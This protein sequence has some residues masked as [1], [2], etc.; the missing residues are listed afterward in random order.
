MKKLPVISIIIVN[1]NGKRWLKPC[2]E[3]VFR[4]TYRHFEVI[5]VDNGSGDDSVEYLAENFPKVKV[6]PLDQNLGFA[7]GNNAGIAKAKGDIVFL[8]NNDTVIDKDMLEKIVPIFD[9]PKIG[10]VQPKIV[11]QR[12]PGKLDL[13]G[14]FWT[15]TTFLSYFGLRADSTLQK[16][17]EPLKVFSNKGAAMFVRK[18]MLDKIGSFDED[19]WCYYE[20]TDLCHRAWL[21][22]FECWY[23]PV[24]TCHHANG[25]TS[26]RLENSFIQFHNFK[27]KFL[28]FLKNFEARSLVMIIPTYLFCLLGLIVFFGLKGEG[29]KSMA[30]IKSLI[31]NVQKFPKT[32]Q[33]RKDVQKLRRLKD[34]EYLP[35][36][37]KSLSLKQIFSLLSK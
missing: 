23:Y 5:L 21:A 13:A 22:G 17:N 14:A 26:L 4:Q 10:T 31:W 16:Y 15:S 2:L 35:A 9:N 33:K 3:S 34:R 24:S 8:L 7:K 6:I 19:F 20:E 11:L 1:W 37:S 29:S 32:L 27:N 18:S 30:L 36:I 28:S 12:E 25:G